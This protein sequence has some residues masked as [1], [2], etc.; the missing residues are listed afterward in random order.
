MTDHDS[1]SESILVVGWSQVG[2]TVLATQLLLRLRSDRGHLR[3]R[4]P[5][6]DVSLL[7]SAK[8]ALSEGLAP[9]HTPAQSLG[10]L[11]LPLV[12]PVDLVW[13]DYGG[14]QVKRMVQDA[15][16]LPDG[17]RER[18]EAAG[19]WLLLVRP[20]QSR[21]FED[22]L[23][24]PLHAFVESRRE[25]AT[26][27]YRAAET[28][29][30]QLDLSIVWSDQALLVEILQIL[31]EVKGAK[32]YDP[33]RAPVL[34]VGLT[35]WD[36]LYADDDDGAPAPPD[37]LAERYPLLS[38]YIEANWSE[39]RRFVFGLSAQGRTLGKDDPDVEY[40]I[41]GPEGHGY[42]IHPDGRRDD[43]LTAP[44]AELIARVTS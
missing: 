8:D 19:G 32:L 29:D 5:P 36:E 28:P 17:W 22:I 6:S 18:I 33:T 44:I 1:A 11:T 25:Q 16:R 30:T 13:P 10:D 43:D 24:R 35:C 14:E 4:V 21:D 7:E 38:S 23:S 20:S 12:G 31:R 41:T 9:G 34:A 42:V 26:D 15:R 3:L 40:A 39:E 27:A 37:L 2:K